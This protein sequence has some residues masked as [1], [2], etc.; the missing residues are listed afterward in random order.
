[1][2]VAASRLIEA[3]AELGPDDRALLNLLVNHGVDERFLLRAL[4]TDQA[5][6][7]ARYALLAERLGEVLELPAP[8]VQEQ[9]DE[10]VRSAREY[11]AAD[12]EPANGASAD[13]ES[14]P[15]EGSESTAAGVAPV[16]TAVADERSPGRARRRRWPAALLLAILVVVLVV[17]LSA[18]GSKHAQ[19]RRART[20][21]GRTD[22]SA[23]R[24]VGARD[25][26]RLAM[27]PGGPVG[28]TGSIEV[29]GPADAPRLVV[30]A[31][32]LPA[33]ATDH[34]EVWLYNSVIDSKALANLGTSGGSV[35]VPLPAGYRRYRWID[36]SRQPAGSVVH[37]G[38]SVLRVAVPSVV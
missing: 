15:T 28:A 11:G 16:P 37:S 22:P 12:A 13:S 24:G 21:A 8:Y 17:I 5:Q 33:V 1:M 26:A 19:G 29:T 20:V 25:Q 31:S 2:H 10:L 7:E 9:L 36:I 32:G 38:L 23:S 34:Y 35:T 6:L 3:A 4:R 27:L 14:T 30:S 18:G